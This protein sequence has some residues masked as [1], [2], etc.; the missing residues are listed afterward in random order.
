VDGKQFTHLR[1]AS[2]FS[3]K[4]GTALP[5]SIIEKAAHLGMSSIALTDR[6]GMSGAIRFAQSCEEAGIT[7]ILGINLSFIQ[8]RYRVTLLAKAGHLSSLY[9]LVTAIN[10]DNSE[11][12]LTLELLKRFK[13]YSS[14]V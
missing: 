14:N 12:L 7:P 6:E 11:S 3:F 2:G 5:E 8:K 1:V 4:F 13:E 10:M 9:R